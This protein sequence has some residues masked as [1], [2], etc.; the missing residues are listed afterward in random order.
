MSWESKKH[1]FS[2]LGRRTH[3]WNRPRV[4]STNRKER[5][6]RNIPSSSL[7]LTHGA[8]AVALGDGVLLLDRDLA[9][10]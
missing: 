1:A 3:D 9:L 4:K 6:N 2:C 10:T 5:S 7:R 8:G